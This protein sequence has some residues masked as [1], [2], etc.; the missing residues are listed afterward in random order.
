[1][2]DPRRLAAPAEPPSFITD[3]LPLAAF[4][5]AQGHAPALRVAGSSKILFSFAHSPTLVRDVDAFLGGRA[6][7][8]P[9][10]FNAARA[11]LRR[12]MDTLLGSTR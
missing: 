2:P 5:T 1:M 3:Q 7:V 12:E 10:A 11:R 9:A 8:A 4:L 6:L